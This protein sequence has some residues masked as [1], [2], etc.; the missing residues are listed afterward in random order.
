MT[1]CLV[2]RVG[3]SRALPHLSQCRGKAASSSPVTVE[4]RFRAGVLGGR[5]CQTTL[6]PHDPNVLACL[7]ACACPAP[8]RPP[9]VWPFL[10]ASTRQQHDTVPVGQRKRRHDLATAAAPAAAAHSL[11]TPLASVPFRS[12][13]A[14][15]PFYGHGTGHRL[16]DTCMFAIRPGF[17]GRPAVLA[18]R[19]PRRPWVSP[20]HFIKLWVHPR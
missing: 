15:L 2:C 19:S 14:S 16:C 5:D 7:S 4:H 13:C 6:A 11:R 1:A 9:S 17:A 20:G 3:S 10:P 18:A 12:G 8:S